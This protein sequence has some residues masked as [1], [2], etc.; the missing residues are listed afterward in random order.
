MPDTKTGNHGRNRQKIPRIGPKEAT[1]LFAQC[2]RLLD[3]SAAFVENPRQ[4]GFARFLAPLPEQI[5]E[6]AVQPDSWGERTRARLIS[7]LTSSLALEAFSL[8]PRLWR[9][10]Y[11]SRMLSCPASSSNWDGEG[12][13]SRSNSPTIPAILAHALSSAPGHRVRFIPSTVI[14]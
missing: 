4:I 12:S 13:I 2:E 5:L 11:R 1:L 6:L 3:S 8:N 14:S 7:S 10:S 9:K